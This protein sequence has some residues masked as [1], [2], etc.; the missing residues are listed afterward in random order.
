M[1]EVGPSSEPECG[2]EG[3]WDDGHGLG[4]GAGAEGG[5]VFVERHVPDPVDAVFDGATVPPQDL[6]EGFG[7]CFSWGEAGDAVGDLFG[8]PL[9][10]E[11]T[12]VADDTEF[13]LYKES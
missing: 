4:C 1:F 7:V 5:C 2:D 9:P 10:V 3:V 13:G 12:D 6:T 11:V 8:A